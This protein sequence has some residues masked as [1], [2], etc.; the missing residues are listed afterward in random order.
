MKSKIPFAIL[1]V[2]LVSCNSTVPSEGQDIATT[3]ILPTSNSLSLDRSEFSI[4]C[5]RLDTSRPSLENDNEGLV[6]KSFD[7][8]TAYILNLN[9]NTLSSLPIKHDE[10]FLEVI[11]SPDAKKLAYKTMNTQTN[12]KNLII[13]STLSDDLLTIP[14]DRNWISLVD[15]VDTNGLLI[16]SIRD[17]IESFLVLG[18][19]TLDIEHLN[20]SYPGMWNLDPYPDWENYSIVKTIFDTSLTR[21]LYPR[22]PLSDG[23]L[24]AVVLW[25]VTSNTELAHL[26]GTA[27]FGTTPKWSPSMDR[28]LVSNSRTETA[29]EFGEFSTDQE[30]FTIGRNGEIKQVTSLYEFFSETRIGYFEWS[31]DQQSIAFWLTAGPIDL[32]QQFSDSGDFANE[33]LTVFNFQTRGIKSYCLPGSSVQSTS[34]IWSPD[35]KYIVIETRVDDSLNKVFLLD[36]T[37][38]I[39]YQIA[40]NLAPIGWLSSN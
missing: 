28:I 12:E 39:A 3:R 4:Q 33:R 2:V 23:D 1:V 29:I 19:P 20:T 9:A 8:L 30:L 6:L 40:E 32:P 35:S 14:W 27:F 5:P 21:V 18:L 37:S 31:P 10:M 16:S 11:V 17:G 24:E 34:P 25:D 38:N 7:G 22:F 36:L 13:M 26:S 15:W